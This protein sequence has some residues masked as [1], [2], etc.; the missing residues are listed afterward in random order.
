[1]N[2]SQFCKRSN[3]ALTTNDAVGISFIPL[4]PTLF[5]GAQTR[6]LQR[7]IGMKSGYPPFTK[8]VL[9][10][11]IASVASPVRRPFLPEKITTRLYVID[12]SVEGNKILAIGVEQTDAV[13]FASC[14]HCYNPCLQLQQPRWEFLLP[15]L[16]SPLSVLLAAKLDW[17]VFIFIAGNI[18][19]FAV[20]WGERDSER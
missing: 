16:V 5:L 7:C 8:T 17:K 12:I 19:Y 11:L 1:M 2:S 10:L 4:R 3:E 15:L 9:S 13:L 6:Q 18:R 14:H 20:A